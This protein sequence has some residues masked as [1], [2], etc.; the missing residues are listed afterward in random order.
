MRTPPEMNDGS[1]CIATSE[2]TLHIIVSKRNMSYIVVY[3]LLHVQATSVWAIWEK[4]P[5][6]IFS[7]KLTLDNADLHRVSEA[8]VLARKPY[9]RTYG[10]G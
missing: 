3:I 8:A 4:K 6:S 7:P 5:A 9:K 1:W 2:I 10:D